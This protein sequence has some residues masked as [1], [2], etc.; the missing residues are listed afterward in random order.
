MASVE[1]VIRFDNVEPP[2]GAICVRPTTDGVERPA[3]GELEI[4][5]VGWLGLICA[6]A[7]VATPD[8][9]SGL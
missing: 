4:A 3:K 6:I 1:V 5:F 9:P 7:D 8:R 2:Q